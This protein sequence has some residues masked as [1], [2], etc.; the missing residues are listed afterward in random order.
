[1]V[2]LAS[3][4]ELAVVVAQA[5]LRTHPPLTAPTG[6]RRFLGF[7]HRVPPPALRAARRVLDDD[8]DYRGRVALVAT[9]ELVGEA[10]MLY[11]TRTDGW[12]ERLDSLASSS[13]ADDSGGAHGRDERRLERRLRSAE[14]AR[15]R[16]EA[17]VDEATTALVRARTAEVAARQLGAEAQRRA[18]VADARAHDLAAERDRLLTEVARLD[19]ALRARTQEIAGRTAEADAAAT[20]EAEVR[21]ELARARRV[22]EAVAQAYGAAEALRIA[23]AEARSKPIAGASSARVGSAAPMPKARVA[24]VA[25]RVPVALPPATFDDAPEAVA[26]LLRVHNMLV[27]VDGYNVA[28]WRWPTAVPVDLR[29]RLIDALAE[30][31]T[32]TGCRLHVVFDGIDPTAGGV[33]VVRKLVRVSFSPDGHEADDVLLDIASSQPI[34]QPV[35]VVSSDNR[36]RT[37]AQVLGVNTCLTPSFVSAWSAIG[38]PIAVPKLG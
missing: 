1:M 16:A 20:R 26:H 11:L 8:P 3:V 9:E 29:E 18:D 2:L 35:L 7:T 4:L 36:V 21:A 24:Q 32:R 5:G 22:E 30:V 17:R 14:A 6:L 37:G 25:R 31:G 38:A 34:G 33:R 13:E 27:L 23:I 10:G 19:G 12:E 15:V 28:K